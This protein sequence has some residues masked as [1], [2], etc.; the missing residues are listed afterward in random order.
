MAFAPERL[1]DPDLARSLAHD[2]GGQPGKADGG[3]QQ[4][5]AAE[6]GQDRRG[7]A[8]GGQ[9]F[10]HLSVDGLNADRRQRRIEGADLA[11]DQRSHGGARPGTDA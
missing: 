11:L 3:E 1:A 10:G 7:E 5:H 6:P 9:A 2:V 8:H 4:G